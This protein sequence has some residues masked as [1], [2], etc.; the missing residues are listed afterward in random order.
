MY[1]YL[2]DNYA[3][4]RKP[5]M[6]NEQFYYKTRKNV[7]G[8]FKAQSWRLPETVKQR[9]IQAWELQFTKLFTSLGIADTKQYVQKF[10]EPVEISIREEDFIKGKK[11]DKDSKD[12]AD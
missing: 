2:D 4:E 12:L 7:I 3:N 6:T 11:A 5:D 9:I 10:I 1:K 8:P